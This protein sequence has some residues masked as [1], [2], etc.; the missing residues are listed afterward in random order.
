M[1]K[2]AFLGKLAIVAGL[3]LSLASCG[4]NVEVPQI[5]DGGVLTK[6]GGVVVPYTGDMNSRVLATS[7]KINR[8]KILYD[9]NST[10]I[11]WTTDIVEAQNAVS[12]IYN[13]PLP[14][15]ATAGK[16]FL[17]TNNTAQALKAECEPIA[18][19]WGLQFQ[20]TTLGGKFTGICIARGL[21]QPSLSDRSTTKGAGA[22]PQYFLAQIPMRLQPTA[23]NY[24]VVYLNGS[25]WNST[26]TAVCDNVEWFVTVTDLPVWLDYA[27]Y[28]AAGTI[29]QP[30]G[31]LVKYQLT[32]NGVLCIDKTQ[33]F[34]TPASPLYQAYKVIPCK[35]ETALTT[36]TYAVVYQGP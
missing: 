24:G 28:L 19:Q 20:T 34:G 12:G 32:Q 31:S 10:G 15:N 30:S 29:V 3:A 27:A 7:T 5:T 6:G 17:N 21:T 36:T 13:N 25:C 11:V 35:G 9:V 8:N 18:S 14:T 4:A 22:P 26:N 33:K 1:L 2:V 23:I 16:W